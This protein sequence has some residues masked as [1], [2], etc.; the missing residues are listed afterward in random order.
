M[1]LWFL[2]LGLVLISYLI[3]SISSAVI[4]S[5]IF[6]LPDPRTVGSKNPG[7]T[8]MLRIG[9][10]LPAIL[11]LLGDGLKGF[12]PVF[13][14][15][16][17]LT[18]PAFSSAA[19]IIS[20]VFLAAIIGHL[21]PIFLNFKGGKGVATALG[22]LLALKFS[23]GLSFI[24]I[25]LGVALVT[26]YSALSAL[27]A[28]ALLPIIAFWMEP[29]YSVAI[30]ISSTLIF[31]HHRVNIKNLWQGKESKIGSKKNP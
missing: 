1:K 16:F 30:L 8:N 9:G 11:T 6:R 2:G 23:L 29:Q 18:D 4:V 5:K 17:Y 24:L 25:W 22:G 19:W 26:R 28:S 27:V 7:T 13:V 20:S 12:L 3:G 14:T 31:W 21:Y 15:Q 10:K